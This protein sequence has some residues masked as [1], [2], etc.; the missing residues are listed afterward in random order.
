MAV[1]WPI[2]QQSRLF[3]VRTEPNQTELR[4]FKIQITR[5]GPAR[6]ASFQYATVWFG[7]FLVLEQPPGAVRSHLKSYGAVRFNQNRSKPHRTVPALAQTTWYLILKPPGYF[8][9][10][11]LVRVERCGSVQALFR[12]VP[13]GSVAIFVF[14]NPTVRF[15][16]VL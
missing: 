6:L 10:L 5:C 13:C 1:P 9:V 3:M 8:K 4:F 16:A 14:E 11:T 2:R 7:A 12:I 15:G